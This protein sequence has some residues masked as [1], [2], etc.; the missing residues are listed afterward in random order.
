MI[1]SRGC[2]RSIVCWPGPA[3]PRV[4]KTGQILNNK[5]HMLVRQSSLIHSRGLD[6]VNRLALPDSIN[7]KVAYSTRVLLQGSL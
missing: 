2:S 5:G 1:D 4:N 7:K 3:V 6:L